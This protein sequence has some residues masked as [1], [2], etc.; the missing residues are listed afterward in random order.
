MNKIFVNLEE[1][2]EKS[3]KVNETIEEP[4]DAE[5]T[6]EEACTNTDNIDAKESVHY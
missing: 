5:D 6:T 2:S 1:I 3:Y 4:V